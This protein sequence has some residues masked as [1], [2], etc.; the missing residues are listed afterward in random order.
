MGGA[1]RVPALDAT[2]APPAKRNRSDAANTLCLYALGSSSAA[3]TAARCTATPPRC[4]SRPAAILRH[5]AEKASYPSRSRSAES[6]LALL[7][8]F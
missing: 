2:I 1:E 4:R 8:K 5:C 7:F 6:A 3:P